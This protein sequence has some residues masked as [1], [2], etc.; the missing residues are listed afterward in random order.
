MKNMFLSFA[1]CV[2]AF[3][4]QVFSEETNTAGSAWA[5]TVNANLLMSMNA[6]T[7]NWDGGEKTGLI[8]A[9]KIDAVAQRQLNEKLNW[10]NTLKLAFGQTLAKEETAAGDD[11]TTL[12]KSTDLIDFESVLAATLGGK[13]NPYGAARLVSQF[14]DMAD[15]AAGETSNRGVNP[16]E[17]TETVGAAV[18]KIKKPQVG[19]T[20]RLGAGARQ[21]IDRRL[22]DD[23]GRVTV[24]GGLELASVFNAKNKTDMVQFT[25]QVTVYEAIIS[26]KADETDPVSGEKLT[27]WRYPDVN[28]EN[29]VIVNVTKYLMMNLAAQ[30]KYDREIDIDP[31]LKETLSLGLTYTF[32]NAKE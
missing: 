14:L 22:T 4:I 3:A 8:Y 29:T 12:T 21:S 26:T 5:L 13:V 1:F 20:S 30:L 9:A 28:W 7:D 2:A 11:T 10:K 18:E 15:A 6:Y 31:R 32:S 27:D 25:S 23:E 16:A 17:I 19:W 24:D